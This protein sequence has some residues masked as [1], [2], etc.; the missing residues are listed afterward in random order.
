M[1]KFIARV[2]FRIAVLFRSIGKWVNK[3]DPAWQR[4]LDR[5]KEDGEKNQ[6]K[7]AYDLNDQ[8]VVFDLGGF[9]GEW[10][11]EIYARSR[12]K[13]ELFEPHPDFA[14]AIKN[15]FKNNPDIRVH[16]FGLANETAK[17]NL[18]TD[19][20]STSLFKT[21]SAEKTVEV[22]LKNATNFLNKNGFTHIDLI[23]INIEG[24]EYDLLEHLIETE[25]I[26]NIDQLQIQFHH[27]IPNARKRMEGI[28]NALSKTHE[29]TWQFEFLWESWKR[30]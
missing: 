18:A 4:I 24:G 5:W 21:A 25:W 23:K 6:L 22:L 27:F 9:E 8:S 20:E 11:A 12:A 28:Q 26:K 7:Y 15:R 10:S 30:K 1:R 13:I 16:V 3:K 29:L 17:M 19:A 2:F 14:K